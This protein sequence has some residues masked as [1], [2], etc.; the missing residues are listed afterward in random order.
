MAARWKT[1]I[2]NLPVLGPL[3][4]RTKLYADLARGE[5]RRSIALLQL[6]RPDGLFQPFADTR[7]DRYPEIFAFVRDTLGD[8]P[9]RALL[10]F[11]CSTGEEAASLRHYF[12]QARITGI[13]VNPHNIAKARKI[14]DPRMQFE[15]GSTVEGENT[16]DAVFAMAV[17]RHG[18][19]GSRPRSCAHLIRFDAFERSIAALARAVKPGGLFAI[20]HANFRFSDT[21]A[22]A[23]FAPVLSLTHVPAWQKTPLYGRDNLLTAPARDDG[24]Y[25]KNEG[26]TA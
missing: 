4:W 19:L 13:D 6:R 25:R 23:G 21:E 18:R 11:G 17:F 9:E 3:A 20:I 15:V 16:F 14:A 2:L 12:P 1:A 8:G 26:P 22:A 7:P 24:V 10:S 5:P